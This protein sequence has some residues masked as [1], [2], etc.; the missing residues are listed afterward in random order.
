MY[1][2]SGHSLPTMCTK[3]ASWLKP[4]SPDKMFALYKAILK[5]KA[6]TIPK[7]LKNLCYHNI[8]YV[9]RQ[10]LGNNFLR[11]FDF[12]LIF[13]IGTNVAM[14]HMYI[15]RHDEFTILC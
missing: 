3:T 11:K 12:A 6:Y 14:L 10:G 2:I 15:L 8:V 1:H 13:S 9:S 5:H 7:P 4:S